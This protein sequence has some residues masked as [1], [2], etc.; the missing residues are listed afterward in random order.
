MLFSLLPQKH[1][2]KII[3]PAEETDLNGK[4]VRMLIYIATFLTQTLLGTL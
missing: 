4:A 2:S 3:T 1:N